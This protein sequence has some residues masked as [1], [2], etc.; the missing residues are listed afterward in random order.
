MDAVVIIIGKRLHIIKQNP[1][2]DKD[3]KCS[4][5]FTRGFG[6][7]IKPIGDHQKNNLL[8]SESYQVPGQQKISDGQPKHHYKRFGTVEIGFRDAH[9]TS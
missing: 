2:H 4:N 6:K 8:T 9:C 3:R 7:K 5:E 1:V